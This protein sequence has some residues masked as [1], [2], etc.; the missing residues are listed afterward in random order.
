MD[1]SSQSGIVGLPRLG[2]FLGYLDEHSSLVA[3]IR[4]LKT[5]FV[6]P[7][8]HVVFDDCLETVFSSGADDV[9][10]DSICE[11]LYG[12]SCEIYATDEYDANDN[13]VYK[14][15]PLDEVWLDAEGREQSKI[16]LRKQRKRNEELMRNREMATK[17]MALTPATQGGHVPDIPLPNGALISNDD[18]SFISDTESEGGFG[19]PT[20]IKIVPR[21][22]SQMRELKDL[23][24]PLMVKVCVGPHE[25]VTPLRG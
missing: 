4:H 19:V 15:P 6:S 10:V 16:E 2:Q 5:G 22:L 12:T 21:M 11:N 8:Y 13:L 7:Q 18:D 17:D 24:L 3:N 25:D 20:L 14:S 1:R 23:T 9:L